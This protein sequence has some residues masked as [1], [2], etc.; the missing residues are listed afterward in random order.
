MPS[1]A[2]KTE[3]KNIFQANNHHFNLLK[4][5]RAKQNE[6]KKHDI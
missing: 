5:N 6:T 3:S 1:K 4:Q 2:P